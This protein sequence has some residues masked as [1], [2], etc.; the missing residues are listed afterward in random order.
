M[1]NLNRATYFAVSLQRTQDWEACSRNPV[2]SLNSEPFNKVENC[3]FPLSSKVMDRLMCVPLW[4]LQMFNWSTDSGDAYVMCSAYLLSFYSMQCMG[5]PV[6]YRE[7]CAYCIYIQ[8]MIWNS[9]ASL[10]GWCLNNCY[11]FYI[12][13]MREKNKSHL[14]I[15]SGKHKNHLWK[16]ENP[17]E[18]HKR[19]GFIVSHCIHIS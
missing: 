18:N 9:P 17:F 3:W 2:L 16:L 19:I 12:G 6:F 7:S 10:R 4:W 8:Y 15:S 1:F 5:L 14:I 13:N 11:A